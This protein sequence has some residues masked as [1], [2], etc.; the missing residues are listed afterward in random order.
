[1]ITFMAILAALAKIIPLVITG[2]NVVTA[3]TPTKVDDD[4]LGKA[5][6]VL[7]TGLK[8]ANILAVNFGKNKNKDDR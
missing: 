8:I 2:A 1:M 4:F 5:T 7:N 3:V 6:P